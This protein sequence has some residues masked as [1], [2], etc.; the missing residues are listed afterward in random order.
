M[1][2]ERRQPARRRQ[3]TAPPPPAIRTTSTLCGLAWGLAGGLVAGGF[4]GLM[5]ILPFTRPFDVTIPPSLD[6][7]L[8]TPPIAAGL[9]TATGMMIG[10]RVAGDHLA[11]AVGA[12]RARRAMIVAALAVSVLTLWGLSP[13]IW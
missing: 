8:I 3:Q 12:T 13:I 1:P 6:I 9:L 5:L 10:S 7:L 2:I 11:R 4:I